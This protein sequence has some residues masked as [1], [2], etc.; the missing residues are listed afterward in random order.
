[1]DPPYCAQDV[2]RCDLCESL[3]PLGTVSRKSMF[4]IEIHFSDSSQEHTVVPFDKR[5]T[6]TKYQKHSTK[7]CDLFCD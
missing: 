1:M 6:A 4:T 7:I 5:G 2:L 3:V